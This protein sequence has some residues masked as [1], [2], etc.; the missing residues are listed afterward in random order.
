MLV[1]PLLSSTGNA[2]AGRFVVT[3]RNAGGAA[4]TIN[5]SANSQPFQGVSR[6]ITFDGNAGND[7]F[8][9]G[10]VNVTATVSRDLH[11]EGGTGNDSFRVERMLVRDD[12]EVR[13]E[14]GEDG[15]TILNSSV[16]GVGVDNNQNDIDIEGGPRRILP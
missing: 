9:I 7:N 12:L 3:G 6:D 4:T 5:G 14:A 11:L 15:V 2:F 13:G 16:G 10:N 8:T 1:R